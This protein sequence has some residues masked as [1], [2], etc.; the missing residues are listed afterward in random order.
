M[1][2]M[3]D[4]MAELAEKTAIANQ[5]EAIAAESRAEQYAA[6]VKAYR[7]HKSLRGIAEVT[8]FSHEGVRQIL[9]DHGVE[10]RGPGRPPRTEP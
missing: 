7:E 3:G 1:T 10:L 9:L 5:Q 6:I 4:V 2:T 8:G